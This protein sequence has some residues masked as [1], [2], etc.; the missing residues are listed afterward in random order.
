[1]FKRSISLGVLAM[2]CAPV[3]AQ[4]KEQESKVEQL[5][6]VVVTD[7]RFALKRENSGKTVIKISKSEIERNQGR[8]IAELINTKSGIEI[9]G[10][11]SNAGQNLGVRVRGGNNN[12]VLVI[13]DGVQV[14]DPSQ[15]NSEYD[16]RLLSLGNIE[17]IEIIKG[18]AS[19]LYGSGA[20]TAVI[21]I[22]TLKA[23]KDVINASVTSTIGTNQSQDDQDFD[24][25]DFTNSVNINGTVNKF[26]YRLIFNQT[27]SNGISA[28]IADNAERDAYSR[29]GL[30]LNLGY[31]FTDNFSINIF[32]N[33]TDIDSDFDAGAFSDSEGNEFISDQRRIGLTSKYAYEGGSVNLSASYSSFE[34]EFLSPPFNPFISEGDNFIL[35]V[36][37]KYNFSNKFYTIIGLNVIDNQATFAEDVDFNII[38]PYINTVYVSGFGLNINAGARLNNHSEYGSNFIYNINPSYT[39]KLNDSHY[40]KF[41]GSYSTSFITPSLFQLFDQFSGVPDLDPEENLTIEGGAELKLG[42]KFRASALYFNREEENVLSFDDTNFIYFNGPDQTVDGLETEVDFIPTKNL[43]LSLNYTFILEDDVEL[44]PEH[45]ANLSVAYNLTP[46]TFASVSYQFTGERSTF[47]RRDFS[48]PIPITLDSFN[49]INLSFNHTFK[50]DKVTVFAGVENLFNEDY[51]DVF[52]FTTRGFNTNIGFK[53]NLL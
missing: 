49:L 10:S 32:G 8:T 33:L 41:F 50:N 29:Y 18:A 52:G 45:K 9:T 42:S 22:T 27:F 30:D 2:L 37:N 38:D 5:D 7:S 35:D 46:R 48:N 44:T 31:R 4:E 13:I 6:E 34:R 53:L 15:I 47:D 39:I 12:Q 25:A 43:S 19:T 11:R 21:N 40:I 23:G 3:F 24:I 17:S 36:Y 26:N 28:A 20:A 51:Q 14:T 1:M 16:L